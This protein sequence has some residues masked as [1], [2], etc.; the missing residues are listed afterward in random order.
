MDRSMLRGRCGVL[1]ALA[2]GGLAG[3][4]GTPRDGALD[5]AQ[6]AYDAAASDAETVNRA[7]FELKQSQ[8]ALDRA[9]ALARKGADK[10]EIDHY[11]YLA[12]RDAQIAQQTAR[13][14]RAQD[15]MA[16]ANTDRALVLA[17]VERGQALQAEQRATAAEERAAQLE[18]QLADLHQSSGSTVLT[19]GDVLFKPGRAELLPGADASLRR[20]AT[21]LRN[22]PG[23][24]VLIEGFTDNSGSSDYNLEL[25]RER[26][27]AVRNALVAGG[28]ESSRILTRGF[29]EAR[30]VAPNDTAAG[31]QLNRRVRVVVSDPHGQ[32]PPGST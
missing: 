26:A 14:K 28:I 20:L 15:R 17:Q 11:A 9:N 3:C 2:L 19:L 16:N 32:F 8:D 4:S 1:A 12:D 21:F 24:T 10:A 23:R 13:L 22:N 18:Q 5:D 27:D 30:P 25:S 6:S 31:R 7:P 29:G